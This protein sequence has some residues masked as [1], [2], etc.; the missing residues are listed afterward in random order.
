MSTKVAI[1]THVTVAAAAGYLAYLVG[2]HQAIPAWAAIAIFA[3]LLAAAVAVSARVGRRGGPVVRTY[4]FPPAEV[5][6]VPGQDVG[7]GVP[8]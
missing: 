1:L 8:G 5:L 3:G 7:D 4:M 6:D 2:Y